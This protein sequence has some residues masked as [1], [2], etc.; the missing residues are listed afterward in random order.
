MRN[1]SLWILFSGQIKQPLTL[2]SPFVLRFPGI[3]KDKVQKRMRRLFAFRHK[4]YVSDNSIQPEFIE[5]LRMATG[6]P[7]RK[8]FGEF[9][10]GNPTHIPERYW[11]GKFMCI[12]FSEKVGIGTDL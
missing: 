10:I 6:I 12:I 8:L 9:D 5:S 11:S 1:H 4:T 2:F 7:Q 3:A